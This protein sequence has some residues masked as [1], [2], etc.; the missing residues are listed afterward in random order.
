VLR[1]ALALLA[2]GFALFHGWKNL[3][4]A[5]QETVVL[6]TSTLHGQD[7]FSTLWVVDDSPHVWI[8]AEDRRRRW[9]GAVQANPE[10]ELR[11][12]GETF[13]YRATP[14]DTAEARA[15]VDARFRAKYGFADRARELLGER[16][17]LPIRLDPR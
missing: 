4:R 6:R 15:Y 9:L 11:R 17:T 3:S 14:Y 13:R 2:I 7:R 10:V 12:H 5:A 16:D 1:Q 8:R